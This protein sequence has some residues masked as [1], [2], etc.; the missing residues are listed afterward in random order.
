MTWIVTCSVW[1]NVYHQLKWYQLNSISSKWQQYRDIM[2]L[3]W[4][5]NKPL[6]QVIFWHMFYLQCTSPRTNAPIIHWRIIQVQTAY[7][8]S[9]FARNE[10][11]HL[12]SFRLSKLIQEACII[13]SQTSLI[14]LR[15]SPTLHE[16][17]MVQLT[18]H[19]V[20]TCKPCKFQEVPSVGD[21]HFVESNKK[22]R[23]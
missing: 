8:D 11:D 17:A 5:K 1:E 4:T 7:Y 23:T 18:S 13:S 19:R 12:N 22:H 20:K 9:Q 2:I 14:K 3:S 6:N 16:A 21:F 10:E 15:S